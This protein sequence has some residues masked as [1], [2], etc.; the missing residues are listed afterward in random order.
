[1][2]SWTTCWSASHHLNPVCHGPASRSTSPPSSSTAS[3]WSTTASVPFSWVRRHQNTSRRSSRRAGP[4]R[5]ACV[6]FSEE[7]QS[8]VSQFLKQRSSQKLD[9]TDHSR[10]EGIRTGTNHFFSFQSLF[11]SVFPTFKIRILSCRKAV[12]LPDA[13]SLMEETEGA[14]DPLFGAMYLKDA[15]LSPTALIQVGGRGACETERTNV[16]LLI[17]IVKC[18]LP[19]LSDESRVSERNFSSASWTY[20]SS[21]VSCTTVQRW[22][23]NLTCCSHVQ[24]MLFSIFSLPACSSRLWGY[25]VEKRMISWEY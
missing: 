8:V 24:I 3:L 15:L 10:C 22:F 18:F 13:L 2:T 4:D 1:M 11:Q 17:I 5:N 21:C 19:L 23:D 16:W 9:L 25:P 6:S 12:V 7:L 20:Q 14:P